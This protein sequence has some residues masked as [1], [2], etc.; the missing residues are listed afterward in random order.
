M[1]TANFIGCFSIQRLMNT[2]LVVVVPE[3]IEFSFSGNNYEF[4]TQ[5][6]TLGIDDAKSTVEKY[7]GIG[8]DMSFREGQG[9]E[10]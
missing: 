5:L 2:V 6:H 1:V 9:K 8:G 10:A 3:R 7:R 4:V